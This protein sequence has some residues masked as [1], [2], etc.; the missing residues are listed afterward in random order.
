[1]STDTPTPAMDPVAGDIALVDITGDYTLD[2]DHST[3]AFIARHAMITKVRGSF[4]EFDGTLHVNATE[5]TKSSAKVTMVAKSLDT[6][7]A[8]RDEHL[9]SNDFFEME[10]Y[11]SL[12]FASSSVEAVGQTTFRV[13]GDLTVKATT[14]PVTFDL[15]YTGAVTDPW[16]N[17]RIGLEGR[18]TVSRK[19]WNLTWNVPLAAGG[20]LVG[21]K[22]TLEFDISAVKQGQTSA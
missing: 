15:E 6:G 20:V 1:M 2:T 16:G 21:D 5:P 12:S 3:L 14:R 13:T 4:K 17:I 22:V 7:V 19:D 18:T 9:R 11:P 10:T 8:A